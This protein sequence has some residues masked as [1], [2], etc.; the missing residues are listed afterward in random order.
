MS[1]ALQLSMTLPTGSLDA[2]RQAVNS[3]P[4]LTEQEE[5]DEEG[6][7]H[8]ALLS[9]SRANRYWKSARSS[10]FDVSMRV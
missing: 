3:V 4:M 8:R 1:S 6:E 2:Y 10:G 7:A 5:R 9:R